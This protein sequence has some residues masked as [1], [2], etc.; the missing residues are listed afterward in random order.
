MSSNN[1]EPQQHAFPESEHRERLG[2]ARKA[3][4]EAELDCC[5]CVG[6][7]LLYYFAGYDAHTHFS[8]Q[9]LVFGSGSE[10]PTLVI[11][12]VDLGRA[13]ITSWVK[14]VRTYRHGSQNPAELVAR[15]VREKATGGTRLAADLKAYALTGA[16]VLSLV[17]FLAPAKLEDF[18][19]TLEAFRF[20]KSEREMA[21]VR[22][23]AR[24]ATAGLVRAREVIRPGVT[25]IQVAGE[26]EAAMREVG[27]EYPAMP[28]WI[29][30][31]PRRGGHKTPDHRVIERGDNVAMEFAGVHRRYHAVTIQTLAVGE[32]APSFNQ[33]YGS[34]LKSLRAGSRAVVAGSPVAAAEQAAVDAL[35]E[36][37]IDASVRARFGY[38]VSVAYPPTWLESL[39]ITAESKQVFQPNMTFVLHSGA[40]DP[41]TNQKI[42]VGGAYA[43]THN[44]LEVLSGGDLE[45]AVL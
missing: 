13:E 10:E 44:G 40:S 38:G 35:T 41:D 11:R 9:A 39:D 4:S 5:I 22:E 16:Y 15:V 32:A 24:F 1:G 23:A 7:E 37:G 25:E 28:T 31:G 43:L 36:E 18:T 20:V 34:A 42:L 19:D 21:Y 2:R 27:S 12:D 26:I 6:P 30:S 3:L 8:A 45:L 29:S 33:A 14:D 17:E